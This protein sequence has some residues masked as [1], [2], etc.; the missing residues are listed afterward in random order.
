MQ[1][2]FETARVH[3]PTILIRGPPGH[4]Q[5]YLGAAL[6]NSLE[7][8]HV[9]S[10]DLPTL[11][12]DSTRSAEATIVQLFAEV[13][14]QKPSV[15]YLPDFTRWG[16]ALGST[17]IATF[18]ALLRSVPPSDPI[19]LL[20][21]MEHKSEDH[22]VISIQKRFGFRKLSEYVLTKPEADARREFFQ[23]LVKYICASPNEIPDPE[24]RKKRQLEEL[25]PAPVEEKKQVL[26]KD[27]LKALKRRDRQTLNLLKIRIQPIMDQI[28][29]NYK[30]FRTPVVD[31]T[32]IQYLFDE[33]DPT[34]F[35]SDLPIESRAQF[36][37]FEKDTD[38]HDVPGLREV[39]SGKFFYN[40]DIVII[41]KRL[42]NGYYKRPSDFLADIKRIAKDARQCGD[43]DRQIK[44]NE[45]LSNVEVDIG[46]MESSDPMFVAEC[47]NVYLR[48]LEREKIA[49]EKAKQAEEE[50]GLMGP[51]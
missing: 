51:P 18:N 49:K 30:R 35:T 40:L 16:E 42:S 38:K 23:A 37:P 11:L 44:G 26:T 2:A 22:A 50:S 17:A 20:G 46:T 31:E 13:K 27:E 41:E 25:P 48:E 7:G 15:I 21:V 29:K 34:I 19:L 24:T 39:A 8:T 3:R 4:G 28:K 45:L 1:Q 12:G 43:Y 36:R 9:Q 33:E 10:F 14:K 32:Q 5:H 47:E 6:L